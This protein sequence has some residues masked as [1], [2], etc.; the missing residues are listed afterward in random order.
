MNSTELVDKPGISD[1]PEFNLYTKE[2]RSNPYKY[3]GEIREKAPVYRMKS[4]NKEWFVTRYADVANILLNKEFQVDDLPERLLKKNDLLKN[5]ANLNAIS[6]MIGDWIIFKQPPDHT[7]LRKPLAK[8]FT[9]KEL[10]KMRPIVQKDVDALIAKVIN[11]G[12][13]EFV[14]DIGKMLPLI[15]SCRLLG[16]PDEYHSLMYQWATRMIKVFDQP[17]TLEAYQ[18]MNKISIAYK[19]FFV[20]LLEKKRQEPDDRLISYLVSLNDEEGMLSNDELLATCSLLII[21]SQETTETFLGNSIHAL[22]KNPEQKEWLMA[23]PDKIAG[24]VEELLRYD[25][26]IQLLIR[27][28]ATEMV[29]GG[30]VIQ[31]GD[32]VLA[33]LAAANHD[34]REF[35][36]PEVLNLARGK[37]NYMSFGYGMHTCIGAYL[38]R[39]EGQVL[40]NTL[41][42]TFPKMELQTE[43][44]SWYPNVFIRGLKEL[45]IKLNI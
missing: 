4:P 38:A 37:S 10:E 33:S 34:P 24:A 15:T 19:E 42:R 2:Y 23:N 26:P 45:P 31:P 9:P 6:E 44:L 7:R 40:I 32:R 29:I 22:L 3:L 25:G 27:I 43:K 30:Q 18:E 1:A 14:G 16:I 8:Y 5:G 20:E 36:D 35:E 28:P 21:S 41:L 11:K 17:N 39:L 13:M 12:E